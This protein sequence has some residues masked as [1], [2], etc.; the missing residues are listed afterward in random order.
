MIPLISKLVG[1]V[2]VVYMFT[3]PDVVWQFKALGLFWVMLGWV[4]DTAILYSHF[5]PRLK[6]CAIRSRAPLSLAFKVKISLYVAVLLPIFSPLVCVQYLICGCHFIFRG[7]R[8]TFK[9]F[10]LITS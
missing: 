8:A 9:G 1:S 3:L 4:G 5:E 10:R 7:Q 2:V 6:A